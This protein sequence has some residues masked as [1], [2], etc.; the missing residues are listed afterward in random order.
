M[1]EAGHF[2]KWNRNELLEKTHAKFG[3]ELIRR[4]RVP[5]ESEAEG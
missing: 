3:T 1:G 2:A 4:P 5:Q